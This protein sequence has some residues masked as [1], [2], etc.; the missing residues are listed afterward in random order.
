IINEL[1][2]DEGRN[3]LI[4]GRVQ[5]NIDRKSLRLTDR[6]EHINV[7]EKLL[8][9]ENIDYISVH[10]SINKNKQDENMNLIKTKSLILA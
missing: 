4:V 3:N 6:I 2:I 5:K 8:Q 7:L 9:K 1:C 10:G